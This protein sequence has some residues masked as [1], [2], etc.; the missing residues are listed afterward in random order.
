MHGKIGNKQAADLIAA[1]MIVA[2][3]MAQADS[4]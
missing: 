1:I 4:K 2:P 3:R